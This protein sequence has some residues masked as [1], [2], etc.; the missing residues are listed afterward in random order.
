M[1]LIKIF[2]LAILLNYLPLSASNSEVI[3]QIKIEGNN[4]ITDEIILMFSQI[5]VGKDITSSAV[6]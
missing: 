3:N 1:R 2:L 6:N 5:D 4:R